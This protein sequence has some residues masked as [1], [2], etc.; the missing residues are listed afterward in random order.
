MAIAERVTELAAAALLFTCERIPDRNT[1]QPALLKLNKRWRRAMP[2]ILI[3]A[4]PAVLVI[5]GAGY[6]LVHVH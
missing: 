5:G 4:I 3:W 6:Y 2:L 1:A